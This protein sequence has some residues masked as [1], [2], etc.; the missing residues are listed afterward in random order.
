VKLTEELY[1]LKFRVR[2]ANSERVH[3][4][5]LR[6]CE[7][8]DQVAEAE[9]H[10][11]MDSPIEFRDHLRRGIA[12]GGFHAATIGDE[13]GDRGLVVYKIE[14]GSEREICIVA[15]YAKDTAGRPMIPLI[16]VV[17]QTLARRFE[18]SSIRFHTIRPGLMRHALERGYRVSEIILRK[19]VELDA[20]DSRQTGRD[21]IPIAAPGQVT[22]TVTATALAAPGNSRE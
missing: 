17:A 4:F 2:N 3:E 5:I 8:T 19:S 7:S 1:P 9:K 18:C 12:E 11:P 6:A 22:D 21:E 16:D 15:Y 13:G 20:M 14:E 10:L